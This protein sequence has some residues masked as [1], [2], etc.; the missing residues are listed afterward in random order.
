MNLNNWIKQARDYWQEFR[1]QA[2][3]EL[4]SENRLDRALQEAAERTHAEMSALEAAGLPTHEAWERV[5]NLYLFPAP[6]PETDD[7]PLATAEAAALFREAM[8]VFQ[9]DPEDEDEDESP[10]RR[11]LP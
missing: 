11:T 4:K 7:E 1:P 5:R 8:Q 2:V 3:T 10:H 6:E 9:P